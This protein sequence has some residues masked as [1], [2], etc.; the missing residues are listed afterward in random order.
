[1]RD[2]IFKFSWSRNVLTSLWSHLLGNVLSSPLHGAVEAHLFFSVK[3]ERS[4]VDKIEI[5]VN[6][7]SQKLE[8]LLEKILE[9]V[10]KMDSIVDKDTFESEK[11]SVLELASGSINQAPT[12]AA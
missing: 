8:L 6:G 2:H 4:E 1:M 3:H 12:F 9:H 5:Q 11:L 7:L 10:G